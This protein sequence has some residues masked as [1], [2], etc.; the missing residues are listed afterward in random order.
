MAA[1]FWEAMIRVLRHAGTS[2][3]PQVEQPWFGV[4]S[5]GDHTQ[6]NYR[7]RLHARKRHARQKAAKASRRRNRAS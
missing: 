4:K 5:R 3:Y 6:R 2:P 7:Q 1:G